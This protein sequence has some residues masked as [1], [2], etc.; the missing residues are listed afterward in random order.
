MAVEDLA[1]APA[2]FTDLRLRQ[3][4]RCQPMTTLASSLCVTDCPADMEGGTRLPHALAASAD[5]ETSTQYAD[6]LKLPGASEVPFVD[7]EG[8][9]DLNG[10]LLSTSQRAARVSRGDNVAQ[11]EAAAMYGSRYAS[12]VTGDGPADLPYDIPDLVGDSSDEDES[13]AMI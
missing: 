3:I 10:N 5:Y 11:E 7:D 4:R 1:P 6:Y 9:L 2:G 13:E 12:D 8:A